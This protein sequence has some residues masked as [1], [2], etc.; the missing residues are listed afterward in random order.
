MEK[1][2]YWR[3]INYILC[4]FTIE[5]NL[6]YLQLPALFLFG[7]HSP[8]SVIAKSPFI[9][10]IYIY[11]LIHNI[12]AYYILHVKYIYIYIYLYVY[13]INVYL[14][15]LRRLRSHYQK[16]F[17]TLNFVITQLNSSI[18]QQFFIMKI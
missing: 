11:I 13:N 18:F 12:Y 14:K 9:I 16:K 10:Y 5:Q 6:Q 17:A 7:S 15:S 1:N 3:S 8:L 2:Y 4:T